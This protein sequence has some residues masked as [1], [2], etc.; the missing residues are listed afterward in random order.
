MSEIAY[1]PLTVNI[2]SCYSTDCDVNATSKKAF[3]PNAFKKAFFW[4]ATNELGAKK[5]PP[6]EK[7]PT[8]LTSEQWR[9]IQRTKIEEKQRLEEAKQAR[10]IE[11]AAKKL[12]NEQK[13]KERQQMR[14]SKKAAAK[15]AA[16]QKEKKRL[17]RLA[18]KNKTLVG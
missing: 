11:R 15:I 1:N 17:E 13:A 9:E 5:K 14:E 12:E 4:P 10:K 7:I 6:K 8:V 3:C 16:E 2:F 18:L